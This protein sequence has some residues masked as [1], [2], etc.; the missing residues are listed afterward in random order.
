MTKR[1]TI[2]QIYIHL[3]RSGISLYIG[4]WA[5]S[6]WLDNS[7]FLSATDFLATMQ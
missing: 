4:L 6:G 1:G 7:A 3:Y 5:N 2:Q